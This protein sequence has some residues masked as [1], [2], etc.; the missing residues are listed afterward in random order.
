MKKHVPKNNCSFPPT[1]YHRSAC[2][3]CL[4]SSK[5]IDIT[6]FDVTRSGGRSTTSNPPLQKRNHSSTFIASSSKVV[7]NGLPLNLEIKRNHGHV[8]TSY[9]VSSNYVRNSRVKM[10]VNASDRWRYRHRFRVFYVPRPCRIES[11]VF[12]KYPKPVI[13]SGG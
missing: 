10:V 6:R 4:Q 5:V 1:R 11:F 8:A 2:Y 12:V 3:T 13:G 9:D 7:L